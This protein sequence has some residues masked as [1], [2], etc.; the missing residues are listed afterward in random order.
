[1]TR[2]ASKELASEHQR[3]IDEMAAKMERG[4]DCEFSETDQTN[5]LENLRKAAVK[6]NKNHPSSMSL[7]GFCSTYSSPGIFRE[8]LKRTFNITLPAKELAAVINFFD[9]KKDGNIDNDEFLTFFRRASTEG[10][11]AIRTYA[12]ARNQKMIADAEAERERLLREQWGKLED[13]VKYEFS[14]IDRL[15]ATEKLTDLAKKYFTDRSSNDGLKSFKAATMGPAM[16]RDLMKR[17]FLQTFNDGELAYFISIYGNEQKEIDCK[18]FVIA[19]NSLVFD[20]RSKSRTWQLKLDRDRVLQEKMKEQHLMEAKKANNEKSVNLNYTDEDMESC[21]SKFRK[22]ALKHD[23]SHAGS[24][25]LQALEVASMPVMDFQELCRRVFR[26]NLS[27]KELGAILSICGTTKVAVPK[28]QLSS[29]DFSLFADDSCVLEPSVRET[30]DVPRASTAMESKRKI[31]FP[32][33]TEAEMTNISCTEFMLLFSRLQR[34]EKSSVFSNRVSL[35][36][37]V[38]NIKEEEHLRAMDREKQ[39]ALDQI[40]FK[41]SDYETLMEKLN[42]ACQKYAIDKYLFLFL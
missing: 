42:S 24:V 7:D 23:K 1:L 12:V 41:E 21:L 8:M 37:Q 34:T 16:W 13:K 25:S 31:N 6:F 2:Q 20:E 29:A 14:E 19:F 22:A 33:L 9:T 27:S 10:R 32:I 35:L 3:K 4:I 5:G 17:S 18:K 15:N 36:Q 26:I 40:K 39:K 30:D 11:F 38:K 28:K